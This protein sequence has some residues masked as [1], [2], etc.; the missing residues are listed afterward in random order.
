MNLLLRL[1]LISAPTVSTALAE[2]TRLVETK[3]RRIKLW[4]NPGEIVSSSS[5]PVA[6]AYVWWRRSNALCQAS[7]VSV[8]STVHPVLIPYEVRTGNTFLTERAQ[9]LGTR[10][11]GIGTG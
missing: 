9:R 11:Y 10:R 4:S 1:R 8:Q 6:L 7:A 2:T 3:C 5:S